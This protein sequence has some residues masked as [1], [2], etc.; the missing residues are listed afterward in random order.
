MAPDTKSPGSIGLGRVTLSGEGAV[1]F[2]VSGS[3]GRYPQS[4]FRVDEA[5]LFL[6][7]PVYDQVYFFGNLDLV[8]PEAGDLSVQLG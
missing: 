2:F 1:G 5:R 7:A 4:S 8:T 3:D 6:D